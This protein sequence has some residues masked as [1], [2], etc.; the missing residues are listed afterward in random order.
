M[1]KEK[2][3]D[4]N[5][6]NDESSVPA[7]VNT[8]SIK[9]DAKDDATVISNDNSD[10]VDPNDGN[11]NGGDDD[12]SNALQNTIVVSACDSPDHNARL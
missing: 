2:D 5:S 3:N 12:K 8:R 1:I 4:N 11:D 10:D 7:N 9:Q 6:N